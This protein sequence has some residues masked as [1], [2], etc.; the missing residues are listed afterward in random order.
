M[1]RRHLDCNICG[2]FEISP[3]LN[4]K[5]TQK[6]TPA[7]NAWMAAVCYWLSIVVADPSKVHG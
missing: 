4:T 2:R 6:R 5:A 7:N 1:I 3:G